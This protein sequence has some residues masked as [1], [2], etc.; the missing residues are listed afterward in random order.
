MSDPSGRGGDLPPDFATNLPDD[1]E[2]RHCYRH[3]QRETGVSCSNCG[4]PICHECMIPAPVGFRCPEC[5][6]E[7]SA[8]APRARVVTRGQIR[9]R[10]GAA[11]MGG[12][13]GM[14]VTKV[15]V[16]INVV[17]FFLELAVGASGVMGGGSAKAL[18]DLGA[19]VPAF[20]FVQH[21]YW[22]LFTS[23]FL[24]LGLLHLAFNM[25]ALWVIGDYVEATLGRLKFVILYF[26][27]AVAGSVLVLVAAPAVGLTV[28]A[29]GAVYGVFGALAAHAYINRT[30]DP[31]SRA[32]LGNVVFLIVIN[33][34][35]TFS[36]SV[37][38]WQAHIGG[39]AAGAATMFLFTLGGRKD[40]HGRFDSGDLVGALLI[41][42]F[43]VALTW[44]RVT[45]FVA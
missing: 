30:R 38:S 22:R 20:V 45:T 13:R 37:V 4:R 42:G 15:L 39:L 18:I 24:H 6:R 23:A 33:L 16:A 2:V 34:V 5:V 14:S 1:L 29:S 41:V 12:S 28:G 11:G 25:W 32:M 43:L 3:P 35:F 10:W 40:P 31:R 17:F 8:G 26:V 27:S 44:W 7:Q 19:L 9:S 21:E 36:S